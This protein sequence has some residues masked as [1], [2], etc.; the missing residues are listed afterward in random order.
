MDIDQ[1]KAEIARRVFQAGYVI[2]PDETIDAPLSGGTLVCARSL[3]ALRT[4]EQTDGAFTTE[5]YNRPIIWIE[6]PL[7]SSIKTDVVERAIRYTIF[8]PTPRVLHPEFYIFIP[9]FVS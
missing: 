3:R 6:Y 9:A 4:I 1:A 7:L 8:A 2:D 5:Q